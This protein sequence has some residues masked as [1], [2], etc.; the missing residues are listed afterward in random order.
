MA[1]GSLESNT[2]QMS[3]WPGLGTEKKT[4]VNAARSVQPDWFGPDLI[5]RPQRFMGQLALV[6]NWALHTEFRTTDS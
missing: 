4:P 5:R 2:T 6:E 1:A 3:I